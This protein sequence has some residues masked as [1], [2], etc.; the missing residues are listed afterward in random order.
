MAALRPLRHGARHG[1]ASVLTALA[2]AGGTLAG[3]GTETTTTAQGTAEPAHNE[4]DVAFAAEMVPHHRQGLRL[5]AMAAE[6]GSTPELAELTEL[7]DRVAAEQGG[8]IDRMQDWLT[9]WD[10]ETS[11]GPGPMLDDG[12]MMRRSTA[13]TMRGLMRAR[14]GPWALGDGDL[15]RLAEGWTADFEHHWLRL[16]ITHHQGAISM[17]RHE[18]AEGAYPPAVALAEDI[19]TTQQAEVEQMQELLRE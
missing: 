6:R 9:A 17:A 14:M 18:I 10:E 3:C 12:T 16:M 15:D 2:L 5:V 8:Q 13:G 1:T 4:A 19:V 7:T 11:Y